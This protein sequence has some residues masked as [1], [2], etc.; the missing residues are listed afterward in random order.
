MDENETVVDEN[1]TVLLDDDDNEEQIIN[2][3]PEDLYSFNTN[4]EIKS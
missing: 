1:E 3:Y 4:Y 2:N